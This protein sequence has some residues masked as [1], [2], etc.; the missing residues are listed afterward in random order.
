MIAIASVGRR[1]FGWLPLFDPREGRTVIEP[2]GAGSGYWAG[3]PSVCYDESA[4]RFYLYYRLRE[5]R[6]VRGKECRIAT[7]EDGVS[8]RTIW[9]ATQHDIGTT[10]M[11]RSC[12]CQTEAG[13]W[14]LYLSYVH[15]AG[16][17][18]AD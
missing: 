17:A 13:L 1:A 3:A 5:P 7:S 8:F 18:L 9:S 11:E 4:G 15:P 16:L 12:I 10:S 2:T 6:P 14:R